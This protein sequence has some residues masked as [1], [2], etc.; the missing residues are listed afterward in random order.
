MTI[1]P[2]CARERHEVARR[3]RRHVVV[4][5]QDH[6]HGDC[7]RYRREVAHR[8]VRQRRIERRIDRDGI[9]HHQQRVAVRRGFDRA[10][11]RDIAAAAG[12]VLDHDGFAPAG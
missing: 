9:A 6:R 5:H 10:L 8:I 3:L 4:H 2:G 12:R 1:F 7:E 11:D